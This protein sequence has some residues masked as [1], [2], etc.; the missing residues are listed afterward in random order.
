MT[1]TAAACKKDKNADEVKAAI[2]TREEAKHEAE[3]QNITNQTIVGTK[4]R[5][6]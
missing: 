4:E 2:T 6:I 5:I 3:W 1:A